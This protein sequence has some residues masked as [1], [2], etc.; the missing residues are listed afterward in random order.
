[1]SQRPLPVSTFFTTVAALVLAI[2]SPRIEAWAEGRVR[3]LDTSAEIG[4][5]DCLKTAAQA[6][7]EEDVDAFVRCFTNDQRPKLRRKAA[8]LFVSHTLDLDLVDTHVVSESP[9]KTELA[10][11][12]HVTLSKDAYDIVSVIDLV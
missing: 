2:A 11:K 3:M 4:A 5:A 12:Y 1:M 7:C 10:V 6:V 8:I 9:G